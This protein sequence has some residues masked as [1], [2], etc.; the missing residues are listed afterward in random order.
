MTV[1][2]RPSGSLLGLLMLTAVSACKKPELTG[3]T[4]QLRFDPPSVEFVPAFADGVT[5]Q[6]QVTIVNDGRATLEVT[7]GG[8]GKPF[9]VELPTRLPPGATTL[10]VAWTPEVPGRF[11]QQLEV[12]SAGMDPPTLP[13]GASA[14]EIP[15]CV[16]SSPC[17]AAR[18]DADS[19]TCVEDPIP[20][21]AACDPGTKCLTEARCE[22]RDRRS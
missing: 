14:R 18:F 3:V 6:Q 8:V 15:A 10:I 19:Q 22:A 11:S 2:F 16:A 12:H 13:L 1:T 7:W 20:D 9:E 5:R 21:G 4:N 17:V